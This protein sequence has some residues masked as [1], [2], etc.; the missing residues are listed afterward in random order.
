MATLADNKRAFFVSAGIAPSDLDTMEWAYY[1]NASGLTP[2]SNYSVTD[3]KRAY[4]KIAL[5]LTAAQ[6]GVLSISDLERLYL[7]AVAT[8]SL[9]SRWALY[10]SGGSAYASTYP[11]T[12]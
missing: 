8:D 1:A 5:G 11:S 2:A 6:A 10:Y 3:H 4:M 12:Y 9:G 7:N